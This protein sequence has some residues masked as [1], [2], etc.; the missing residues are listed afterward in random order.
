M[1]HSGS[2]LVAAA[3]LAGL[4]AGCGGS[5]AVAP[6]PTPTPTPTAALALGAGTASLAPGATAPVAVTLTR[7]GGFT[8]AVTVTAT[9]LPTGVTASTEII[10]TGATTATVTLTAAGS[11]PA[12]SAV[13]VSVSGTATGV[14]IASQALAVSVIVPAAPIT[15]VGNDINNVSAGF[16]ARIALS[17][18]GD[19][20]V[21]ASAETA[22]GTTRVYDR[23]GGAWTQIGADI[24]G[25]SAGDFSGTGVDINAAGTRI[26]IGAYFADGANV[27][28]G[29]VRV[30]DL[31]GGAW[32]QVGAD[33]DGSAAG[34]GLG[35]RVALSASGNRLIAGAPGINNSFGTATVFDLVGSVWTQVGNTLSGGN[36]FGEQ[37]DI[38]GDG[39]TIAITASAAAALTRAGS[40]SVFRLSG[41]TW[42]PFGGTLQGIQINDQFGL[43][44]SLSTTGTRI[45][46]AAPNDSA[47]GRGG[48]GGIGGGRVRVFD[49]S[50]S[51]STQV[52]GVVLGV[53]GEGLGTTLALSGDGTRFAANA[54]EQ[55][56]AK[57]YSLVGSA[58]VQTGANI[59][60][61]PGV[62][63]PEGLALS[64][65]G[66][67]VAVGWRTRVRV[68]SITP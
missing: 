5:D 12:A 17:A 28:S 21:V 27:N 33:I 49:L 59:T 46:I 14:T 66:R 31:V 50:A 56:R 37:V 29:H 58:W 9:A 63:N 13:A 19:R 41:A 67:A 68:F 48:L 40:V 44:L 20:L 1:F 16:G 43:G 3:L 32:T 30:F 2:R 52:G 7:G 38:S 64:A 39:S 6:T 65:D 36:E 35:W 11:A 55:N 34:S 53:T 22:N 51:A 54:Q 25:E 18:N 62:S 23:S 24:V 45:A 47:A 15:Q 61:P 8:G 10:A 42:T 26:A 57:V 60:N 4:L